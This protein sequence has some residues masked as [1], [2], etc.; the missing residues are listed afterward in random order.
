MIIPDFHEE[1]T[2]KV[3]N[4]KFS[5]YDKDSDDVLSVSDLEHFY[6]EVYS[7]IK[8]KSFRSQFDLLLDT[9]NTGTVSKDEFNNFL[10]HQ[11]SDGKI[12]H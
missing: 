11:D 3:L 4:W 5:Y 6:D 10:A 9:D 12:R 2:T 8:T 1:E 7:L